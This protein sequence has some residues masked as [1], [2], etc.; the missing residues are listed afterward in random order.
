VSHPSYEEF[1][2]ALADPSRRPLI[3][4]VITDDDAWSLLENDEWAREYYDEWVALAQGDGQTDEAGPTPSD[5]VPAETDAAEATRA[6]PAP[7][8]PPVLLVEPAAAPSVAEPAAPRTGPPRWAVAAIAG[9][10]AVVLLAAVGVGAL[11]YNAVSAAGH[12]GGA[13]TSATPTPGA[14]ADASDDLMP[15]DEGYVAPYSDADAARYLAIV[16]PLFAAG[17]SGSASSGAP[18]PRPQAPGPQASDDLA[19][20]YLLFGA[21][22]CVSL[23]AGF[24]EV[25]IVEPIV[26]A[27]AG[28]L[29]AAEGQT[30]IDAAKKYLCR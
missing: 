27:S 15:W 10:A 25:D 1:Y 20:S 11:V 26:E 13:A 4:L 18:S 2:A 22:A 29:T 8:A 6:E 19:K 3:G 16:K 17:A 7:T 9:G 30:M 24:A 12:G 23:E 21:S 28:K 5:V 14:D